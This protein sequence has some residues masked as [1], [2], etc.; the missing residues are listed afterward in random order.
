MRT[1]AKAKGCGSGSIGNYLFTPQ[2]DELATQFGELR[3]TLL[4]RK[5]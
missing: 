4:T 2:V 1:V 5:R 3:Q